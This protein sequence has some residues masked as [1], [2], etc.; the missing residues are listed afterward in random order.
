MGSTS[1]TGTFRGDSA[2]WAAGLFANVYTVE[3]SEV[4]YQEACTKYRDAPITFLL[5]DS[6][7][8]LRKLVDVLRGP[9]LF[10]LDAHWSGVAGSA[11]G[12][13]QCPLLEELNILGGLKDECVILV[14]DARYFLCPPPPPH[15]VDDWPGLIDI[16]RVVTE[17]FTD[18]YVVVVDDVMVI[19]PKNV[20]TEI[21]DYC[22][23]DSTT[24]KA[25]GVA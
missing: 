19:A 25:P 20:R 10:W 13:D 2:V 15:R 1:E 17:H 11:G 6:R 16:L 7:T 8:A 3:Q 9:S 4:F 23:E 14:D 21:I 5:D 18:R 22:R 12:S 24:G